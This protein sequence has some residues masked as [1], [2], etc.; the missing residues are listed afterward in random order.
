M[1]YNCLPPSPCIPWDP[2]LDYLREQLRRAQI[3][4]EK[5]RLRRELDRLNR[6]RPCPWAMPPV[7]WRPCCPTPTVVYPPSIQDV[8]RTIPAR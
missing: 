8:L 2:E 6:L 7:I 3:E 4:E 1:I 5:Q